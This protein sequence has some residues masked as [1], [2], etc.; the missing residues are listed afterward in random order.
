MSDSHRYYLRDLGFL[1]KERALDAKKDYQ[2]S[3]EDGKAFAEGYLAAYHHVIDMMKNQSVSFNID[4][5]DIS[6]NDFDPDKEL[7][8]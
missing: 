1:V 6:L 4:E 8:K 5:K 3:S 2:N 7:W